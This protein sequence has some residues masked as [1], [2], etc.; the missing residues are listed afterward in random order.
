M[1]IFSTHGGTTHYLSDSLSDEVMIGTVS[2]IFVIERENARKWRLA[3]KT[4]EGCHI[5]ALVF[6]PRSGLTL[7]AH[8]KVRFMP[9]TI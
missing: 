8:I 9:V 6:E 4:L 3:R 5:S 1:A 7:R 2:G